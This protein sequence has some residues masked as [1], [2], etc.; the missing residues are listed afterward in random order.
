MKQLVNILDGNT[1]LVSDRHGDIDPSPDFPTGLF[2]YD[3]RF[4]S[5][6]QLTIDGQRLHS[7]S[8]DDLQYFESRFFLVPGS[9]RITSTRKSPRSGTARS[10]AV[11]PRTSRC[12]TTP[13]TSPS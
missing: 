11:S 4:L 2:S 3:T 9:R 8:V 10:G 12:S 6:W 7:L 1:F 5:V 13:T